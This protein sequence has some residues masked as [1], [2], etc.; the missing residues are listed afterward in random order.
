MHGDQN[1]IHKVMLMKIFCTKHDL[2]MDMSPSRFI[3]ILPTEQSDLN[4]C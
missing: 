3:Q 2:L 1:E 4:V